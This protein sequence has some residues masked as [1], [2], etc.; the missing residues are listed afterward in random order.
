MGRHGGQS[1]RGL[2]LGDALLDKRNASYRLE[3]KSNTNLTRILTH[4]Y[5]NEFLLMIQWFRRVVTPL[6]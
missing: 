4:H 5:N 3:P 2:P 1:P 6:K